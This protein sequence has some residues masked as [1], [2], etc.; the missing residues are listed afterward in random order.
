[1]DG[2]WLG[3]S[4]GAGGV[5]EGALLTSTVVGEA[6]AP[7][8]GPWLGVSVGAGGVFEGALV[9]SIMVGNAEDPEEGILDGWDV[10]RID[11]DGAPVSG[12]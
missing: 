6:E 3:A 7:V 12:G 8:D 4:V 2:P 9:T 10:S 11:T 1:M 5:F